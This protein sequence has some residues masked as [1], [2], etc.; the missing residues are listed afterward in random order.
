MAILYPVGAEILK[1]WYSSDR[2][3]YL[4]IN[5]KEWAKEKAVEWENKGNE[6]LFNNSQG[7]RRYIESKQREC[8]ICNQLNYG[9]TL[10]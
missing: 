10:P 9:Y 6:I 7:I 1:E 5:S 8:F 2:I 4:A 3:N